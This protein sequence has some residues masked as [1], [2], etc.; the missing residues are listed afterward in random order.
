MQR[1]LSCNVWHHF[2]NWSA[3]LWDFILMH[4]TLQNP[5]VWVSLGGREVQSK[6]KL[7]YLVPSHVSSHVCGCSLLFAEL[8]HLL[9]PPWRVSR[10]LHLEIAGL[11]FPFITVAQLFK[12][13]CWSYHS[14]KIT[15]WDLSRAGAP[16]AVT[17]CPGLLSQDLFPGF[18]GIHASM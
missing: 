10:R 14:L 13:I 18:N 5:L 15:G 3:S 11:S 7:L 17:W 12:K 16:Q 2:G 4:L 9:L 1:S 8:S 6:T